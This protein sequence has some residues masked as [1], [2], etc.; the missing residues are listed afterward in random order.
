MGRGKRL[1]HSFVNT[2][3]D[4]TYAGDIWLPVRSFMMSGKDVRYAHGKFLRIRQMQK[5]IRA[6]GVGM[7]PQHAGY[8]ELSL[9]KH[10]S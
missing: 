6:V 5:L 2:L 10:F 8:H 7:R 1:Y 4:F 9:W 3:I